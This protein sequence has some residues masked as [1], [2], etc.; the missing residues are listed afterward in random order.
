MLCGF[1]RERECVVDSRQSS[2]DAFRFRFTV[3]E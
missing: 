1:A 2:F 3:G